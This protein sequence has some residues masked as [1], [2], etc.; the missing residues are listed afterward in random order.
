[1]NARLNES[2]INCSNNN[3]NA[4]MRKFALMVTTGLSWL[5]Y[6]DLK[7]VGHELQQT[8]SQ[9]D[10]QTDREDQWWFK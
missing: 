2:L 10:R 1:L 7:E 8:D 3:N 4:R 5:V 9:I 6:R